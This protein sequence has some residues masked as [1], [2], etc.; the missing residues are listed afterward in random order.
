MPERLTRDQIP[1]EQTW[2]LGDI[3]ATPEQWAADAAQVEGDS[4][5]LVAF[6]RRLAE[7]APTLLACLQAHETLMARL[8][9][10]RIYA[11]FSLAAD[12]SAPA[13]QALSAQADALAARVE[14]ARS[15]LKPELVALPTGTVECYLAQEPGL[16]AYRALL[17]EALRRRGHVL[18]PETEQALAALGESMKAPQTI[19]QMA[20]AVDMTCDP[21]RDEHAREIP[22]SIAG[23]VSGLAQAADRG[24]RRAAYQSL[25]AGLNRQKVTLATALA[26]HIM[27]NVALAR[28]RGYGSA[29]EMM[30]A[31]QQVP[32]TVYQNVLDVVHDEIGPHVRRL[33]RLRARVLG[34]DGLQRY[35]LDAPLDPQYAPATTFEECARLVQD[36]LRLLGDDYGR[37]I[38]AAF[39]DRWI[40]RADNL[41]KRS[42]A[43]CWPVYRVHPYV[44]MTW[45]DRLRSAFTLAHELGHAGHYALTLRHQLLSTVSLPAMTLVVEAPSTAN[46]LLLGQHLLD[47]AVEPRFR[48]WLI[49]Q[50]LG[51]FIHNM[52]T[53]L[54]E[55][56]FERRL[57][58]LA[59]AGKPLTVATIMDVQGEVFERFYAGSVAV[60]DGARLYWAQQPHFYMN[61]FPYTYAAGL[62]CG[63]A[64]VSAMR[65]QGQPAVDRWLHM[66]TL[67]S[68]L[69][70]IEL[71]QAAGV[72]IGDPETL[73]QAVRYFGSL[74]DE[75]E[76]GFAG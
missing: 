41:G 49:L 36:A 18:L 9:R 47:T 33:M 55:G 22:V 35:D 40:D 64:A 19:W 10:L 52:V 20:T 54:L 60:D 8:H 61:L 31:S 57:Y 68:T 5:A 50:S 63:Y 73:R 48:R 17:A 42:G 16:E 75:L 29:T 3:Y 76:Q 38:A 71:A 53:H 25:T 62:A 12:G 46:E 34:L 59:E 27:Q 6:Q 26:T 1:V 45:R 56:H 7:G 21:I 11:Y 39:T 74:V 37:L 23:Y 51:T 4:R 58:E 32:M 14:A 72:D 24:I 28:L 44:F 2:N 65:E 30:L 13:N 66:L 15:F 43:F 69:P 67:G 70:P